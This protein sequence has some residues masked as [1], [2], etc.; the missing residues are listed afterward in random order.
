MKAS[1]KFDNT[2]TP[3]LHG[4]LG[5]ANAPYTAMLEITKPDG[6]TDNLVVPS[7]T[8]TTWAVT[9]GEYAAGEYDALIR[10]REAGAFEATRVKFTL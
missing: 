6:S 5:I 2:T 9:V 8:G 1:I 7:S 3:L 10:P 4:D